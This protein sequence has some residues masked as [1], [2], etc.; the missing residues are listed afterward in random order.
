MEQTESKKIL[1]SVLAIAILVIAVVGISYAVFVFTIDSKKEHI[2]KTGTISMSYTEGMTN[3]MT[4]TNAIPTEDEVGIKQKEYFDFQISTKISGLTEVDYQIVA[5]NVTRAEKNSQ[6][7]KSLEPSLEEKYVRI[8][9]EK[10]QE[11]QYKQVLEPTNFND[12]N[13][14][15]NDE[16]TKLLYSGKFENNTAK[17]KNYT[18]R[19]ILRM[20]L[21]TDFEDNEVQKIFKVK[22]DVQSFMN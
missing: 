16:T 17:E 1:L 20:W 3:I 6:E 5:K 13:S 19:F 11:S 4:I 2:I 15:Q 12:L 21:G 9:L 7:Q 18:D 22:V 8:Y 10:Q 14:I